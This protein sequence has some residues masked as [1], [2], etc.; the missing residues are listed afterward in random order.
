MAVKA[1]WKGATVS[2]FLSWSQIGKRY[3]ELR[4][5]NGRFQQTM[6]TDSRGTMLQLHALASPVPLMNSQLPILHSQL[7]RG[8]AWL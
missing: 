6:Q 4:R 8:F 5:G 2:H 3:W 7:S 1:Y